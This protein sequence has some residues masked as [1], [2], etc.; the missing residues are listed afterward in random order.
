M[1]ASRDA[2]ILLTPDDTNK[3][4][5]VYEIGRFSKIHRSAMVDILYIEYNICLLTIVIGAGGNTFSEIRRQRQKQQL[6]SVRMKG[7]L[8]GIE[9]IPLTVHIV[10]NGTISVSV[11]G[12]QSPFIAYNDSD[13]INVQYISFRLL[14]YFRI[15]VLS[16][17][18]AFDVT[19][20]N[21]L[22]V[23]MI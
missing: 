10:R 12:Q 11:T 18:I 20:I 19:V 7:F 22:F 9:I 23:R 1:L 4:A 6:K 3:T 2:L 8:S 13:V 14:A 21:R 15:F 5:P 16:S 17:Y